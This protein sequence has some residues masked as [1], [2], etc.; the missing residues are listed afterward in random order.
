MDGCVCVGGMRGMFV[1]VCACEFLY[2]HMPMGA[3]ECELM[4]L[5]VCVCGWVGKGWGLDLLVCFPSF[6]QS[7]YQV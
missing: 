4:F 1:Y 5:F 6:K 3:W 2:A 7:F